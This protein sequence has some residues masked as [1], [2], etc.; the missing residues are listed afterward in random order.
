M[1]ADPVVGVAVDVSQVGSIE[2]GELGVEL[3]L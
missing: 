2:L 3:R 1:V